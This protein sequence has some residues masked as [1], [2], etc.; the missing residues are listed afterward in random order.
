MKMNIGETV[1]IVADKDYLYYGSNMKNS[2][3]FP[4][5]QPYDMTLTMNEHIDTAKA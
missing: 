1:K 4:G 5:H 3:D 2:G